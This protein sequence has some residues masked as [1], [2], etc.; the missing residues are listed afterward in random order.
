MTGLTHDQMA[1]NGALAASAAGLATRVIGPLDAVAI[2]AGAYGMARGPDYVEP[3]CRWPSLKRRKWVKVKHRTW[4]HLLATGAIV[5][6]LV[7]IVGTMLTPPEAHG[8]VTGFAVGCSIGW[9]MHSLADALTDGA[10]WLTARRRQKLLPDEIVLRVW[11]WTWTI[12]PR[13]RVYKIEQR[14]NRLTGKTTYV[15]EP[16]RGERVYLHVAQATN[17]GLVFVHVALLSAVLTPPA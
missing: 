12:R 14:R 5:G 15:K 6:L 10:C 1:V 17:I 2:A 7:L 16:S 11:H 9:W 3:L 4:T 13:I 8:A